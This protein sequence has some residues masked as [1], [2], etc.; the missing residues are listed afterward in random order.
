MSSHS[1]LSSGSSSSS[2]GDGILYANSNFSHEKLIVY[3]RALDFIEFAEPLLKK[4]KNDSFLHNQLERSSSSIALNIAE[5]TG[6]FTHKDKNRFYDIARGSAVESAFCLD[7][8][9]RKNLISKDEN[10]I[11][12]KIL[13]EIVSMLFGLIK[14]NS[15]RVYEDSENYEAT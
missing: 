14:S 7:I 10:E 4:I 3:N 8:L 1:S 13:Y 9:L 15:D 11:G 12:K 6:K 2:R 5:G